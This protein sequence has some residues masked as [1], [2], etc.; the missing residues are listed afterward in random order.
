MALYPNSRNMS[1]VAGRHFGPGPGLE[2]KFRDRS[3][4]FNIY[5]CETFDRTISHPQ[6]YGAQTPTPAYSPGGISSVMRCVVTLGASGSG[7]M[8]LAAHG[9]ADLALSAE[10]GAS[11]IAN[12]VG[13]SALAFGAS[14]EA[15]AFTW[16]VFAEGSASITL[17]ASGSAY[18]AASASGSASFALSATGLASAVGQIEGVAPT[19][20]QASG[21]VAAKGW[22]SGSTESAGLTPS[23]IA[24]AV[25]GYGVRS[26]TASGTPGLSAEERALLDA[27]I[28]KANQ[29]QT[30]VDAAL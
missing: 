17:G 27:L 18:L 15:F 16:A 8:G 14:G 5:S 9:Q 24:S 7:A 26:L 2:N 1:L 25:W 29:I 23:G 10:L 19:A 4:R 12:I 11:A 30:K 6:G 20:L 22:L 13:S 28:L 3:D 21:L